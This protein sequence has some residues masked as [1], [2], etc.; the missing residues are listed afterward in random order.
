MTRSLP[1]KHS[2]HHGSPIAMALMLAGICGGC[3]ESGPRVFTAQHYRADLGCL[4][5]YAPLGLVEAGPVGALCAPV[6]LVQDEELYVSTVCPPYPATASLGEPAS[7]DC[8][9]ALAA[10][11]CD[12][13]T[14]SPDAAP[15]P[16]PEL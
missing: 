13:A 12:D 11:L 16:D 10:A 6:C 8:A 14:A 3:D 15:E 5:T 4:E 9:P 1:D 2:R 7:A